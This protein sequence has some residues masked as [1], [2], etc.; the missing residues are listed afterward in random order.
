MFCQ[1][2]LLARVFFT[3]KSLISRGEKHKMTTLTRFATVTVVAC[4]LAACGESDM[5]P[6]QSAERNAA[7]SP[8]QADRSSAPEAVPAE[9]AVER[10]ALARWNALI[11]GDYEA[12]HGFI[13]PGMRSLMPFEY[14]RSMLEGRA[15]EWKAVDIQSVECDDTRCELK[16]RRT[17]IYVG[18]IQA[19]VGQETMSDITE[20]WIKVDGQWWFVPKA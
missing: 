10:R 4:M 17:D 13:S 14:Y 6:D 11:A 5:S 7:A 19:M 1:I 20:R 15:L 18:L 12:A 3:V 8:S 2:D 9:Q 16:I